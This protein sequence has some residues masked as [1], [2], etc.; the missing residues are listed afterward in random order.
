MN[1]LKTLTFAFGVS[2][3]AAM[4]LASHADEKPGHVDCSKADLSKMTPDEREK[5]KAQCRE[6]KQHADCGKDGMDMSKM[7]AEQRE[8]MQA[9]CQQ[10][11][12]ANGKHADTDKDADDT[13]NDKHSGPKSNGNSN[14]HA[15]GASS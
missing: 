1:T 11:H 6:Q 10:M 4:P 3:A 2:L 15:H 8:K 14:S 12:D 5:A 13:P 9:Q 7:T